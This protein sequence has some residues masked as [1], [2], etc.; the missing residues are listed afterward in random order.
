LWVLH[1][2]GL[3]S[4]P[5]H[6]PVVRCRPWSCHLLVGIQSFF[7]ACCHISSLSS[8]SGVPCHS[9]SSIVVPSV[10]SCHSLLVARWFICN[11]RWWHRYCDG[12]G[13]M[14]V[15]GNKVE[16]VR[17][18]RRR[19]CHLVVVVVDGWCGLVCTSYLLNKS[20]KHF[21]TQPE[22]P[23][24]PAAHVWVSNGYLKHDPC[25]YLSNPY[26]HTRTGLRTRDVHHT[27]LDE[28]SKRDYSKEPHTRWNYL[29]SKFSIY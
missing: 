20:S 17:G 16:V 23:T 29:C 25:P 28:G 27:H 8:V 4:P 7:F 14:G 12:C 21:E 19:G 26:P 15:G 11:H 13:C 22:K 1:C 3:L 24:K 2:T 9:L 18:Q 6:F 5:C 10:T